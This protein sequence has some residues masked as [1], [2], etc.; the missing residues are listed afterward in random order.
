[1]GRKR[2]GGGTS[3]AN[4]GTKRVGLD[5]TAKSVS[6]EHF[7]WEVGWM[8]I[9]VSEDDSCAWTWDLAPR[10]LKEVLTFLTGMSARTWGEI[11]ADRTGNKARHKK[12]HD[13]DVADL[14]ECAQDRFRNHLAEVADGSYDTVFRLRYGGTKRVWGIRERSLFRVLWCD[15]KHA[16]YP[17][18]PD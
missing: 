12:H 2:L 5:T 14:A 9:D 8:D 15:L 4:S 18:D 3:P 1:M 11:E 6:Q 16:V 17:S 13:M 7:R 10:D